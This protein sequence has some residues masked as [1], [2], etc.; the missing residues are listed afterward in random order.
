MSDTVFPEKPPLI[1]SS[2]SEDLQKPADAAEQGSFKDYI[3]IFQFAD[4]TDWI[5]NAI[6]LVSSIAAGAT[7][8]LMTIIFGKSITK[9]NNFSAGDSTPDSFTSVINQLVLWYIYLFIARFALSYITTVAIT[10]SATRTVRALRQV[11]LSHTLRQEIWHFD[12]QSNGA[13]ATQVTTNGNRINQGIA[14]KLTFAIQSLSMFFSSFIVALAVQW[15]LTLITMSII[16]LIF[17]VTGICIAIDAVQEARITKTY[18]Q[19]ASLAEEAFSSVKTIQAFWAYAKMSDQYN[20]FLEA[21]HKEGNKKSPNYSILFSTE[22]FCVYSGIALSFWQGFR[23]YQSGEIES[24]GTVFTVVLSITIAAT[25]ISTLAPQITAFTNASAAASELFRVIDKPSLLDPLA[26][27]GAMPATC[28]GKIE[29]RDVNF[30]YPTRPNTLVAK[31]L[32]ID[33]PAGKTTALVGA[34]GCGKSTLVGL[35]ERWYIPNSGQILLDGL[36]VSQYNTKWLRSQI[37]LVQQEPVLFR[38]SVYSNVVNGMSDEQR[39]TLSDEKKLELVQLACISANAHDFIESLPQSYFTEV[40]ERAGMLSGGQRQRIAIARAIVSDPKILLL[41]EATSALDPKAERVVQ[42][43]LNK[44]SVNRTTLI[45]AHR[46]ATVKNADSIAVISAGQ[47]VEQGTHEELIAADGHYAR[48]VNA[49]DLGAEKEEEA[50]EEEETNALHPVLSLKRS[51]SYALEDTDG[52][53]KT[54]TLG[55]GLVRCIIIMLGEQKSL[56]PLLAFSG[57]ACLIAGGTFPGQALLYSRLLGVFLLPPE[58]AKSQAN[59]YALMFFVLALGNLLAYAIIGWICNVIGQVTTHRYRLEMFNTILR[60]DMDFFD[61]PENS[62]GALTSR[63]STLPT[64]LQELISANLLLIFIVLVNIVSSSA[65]ALAYGWKLGLVVIFG[66]LPPLLGAGYLR[67]RLETRMDAFSS[68]RFSSSAALASEAVIAIRTVASLTMES[69]VLEQYSAMLDGIVLTTIKSTLWIMVLFALSQSMDFLVMGLGFWYGST[70][71]ASGEYTT[72]QFYIIFIGVLF[73]GQAAGQFFGYSTSITNATGAANYILW[74]RTLQPTMQERAENSGVG[75]D[76]DENSGA[77]QATDL[78]FSYKQRASAR[79]L[80]NLNLSIPSGGYVALVGPSGCGKSTIIALL[81]RFYDPTSGTINLDN[82][83]IKSFSPRL[84]RRTIALVQQE[85][86]LYQGSVRDNIAIGLE[87]ADDGKRSTATDA[88]L[89]TALRA[90]NAYD[91][92][93]S[94]PA[95]LDTPCGQRGLQFSGGQRQRLSLARALIRQPRLLLLDEATSALDTESERV[96][97]GALDAAKEGRT[98]VAVAHRLSTI[99]AADC[100]YVFSAGRVV[101]SG[102]H[103]ELLARRA[104]YWD[105]CRAQSLDVQ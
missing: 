29:V 8:P 47:V 73:A 5:L 9:F 11:F 20:D 96:V 38:G 86:T 99:R 61:L 75:P 70:L 60:Q 25:S 100:I 65:L 28:Q 72:S 81:E 57:L 80:R 32:C 18:S 67:I 49:Q 89:T 19:A 40:G 12:K 48:L 84:Y 27:G 6:A 46:L 62:S 87:S 31:K 45:I 68:E 35:L 71:L 83:N 93:S 79:V 36:D 95:G 69:L 37:G 13:T 59:F 7:L 76:T 88:Q 103:V 51:N 33:L 105:M 44:V 54:G 26:D 52:K 64:Q 1:E 66:G 41:D 34:S 90:A 23:M 22:Y 98:T 78:S 4:R 92:V 63:C 74:L 39:K 94:L 10:I 53:P 2:S 24:A 17:I 56:Y 104:V 15:K 50:M 101:E 102:T 82:T 55:Y 14:E 21:A 43:A 77:I 30:A 3:R 97:Q 85:P 42:D 16:P 58:A 91:F